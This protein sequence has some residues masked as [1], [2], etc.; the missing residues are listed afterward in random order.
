M[1]DSIFRQ[2]RP[3]CLPSSSFFAKTKI[4]VFFHFGN[5]RFK[6]RVTIFPQLILITNYYYDFILRFRFLFIIHTFDKQRILQRFSVRFSF[7]CLKL[8]IFV[9]L[10]LDTI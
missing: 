8:Q 6:T 10:A 2:N 5:S 3:I 9:F 1:G 4:T 7:S